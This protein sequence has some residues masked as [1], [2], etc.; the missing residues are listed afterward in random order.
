[1]AKRT[2]S[3]KLASVKWQNKNRQKF[4][5]WKAT[6]ECKE[7]GEKETCV[8]D[9]H[10]IDSSTKD[11]SIGSMSVNISWTRL[12]KEISKCIVL[13]ANCHRKLHFKLSQTI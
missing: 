13:C 2:D 8:L 4:R 1:M 11:Y 10:H 5:E 6:Q 7:C 9:L 12:E 3:Q